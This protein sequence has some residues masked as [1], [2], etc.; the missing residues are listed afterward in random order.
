MPDWTAPFHVPR[1]TTEEFQR[2]KAEYV[3][4]YGYRYTIPGFDDIFHIP[5]EAPITDAEDALWKARRKDEISPERREEIEYIKAKRKAKYLDMLGSPL[6]EVLVSRAALLT[7]IDDAQDAMSTLAIAGMVASRALPPAARAVMMTGTGWIMI[8]GQCLNLA[9]FGLA[10]EQMALSRKRLQDQMTKDNP[11][12]KKARLKNAKKLLKGGFGFGAALEVAQTTDQVFGWG[13]SLGAVMSLPLSIITGAAKLVTGQKLTVYYP[14]PHIPRW[15]RI[16]KKMHPAMLAFNGVFHQTDDIEM[17]GYMMAANAAAQMELTDLSEWNPLD[18]VLRPDMATFPPPTPTKGYLLEILEETDPNWRDTVLWP[19]T[20]TYRPTTEHLVNATYARATENFRSY[21][22]RQK[23][24]ELGFIGAQNVSL[25][26]MNVLEALE[27]R[28]SVEYDY[29]AWCKTIHA[30]L[31]QGY[32]PPTDLS[33][34]QKA[35]F[36]GWLEAHEKLGSCPTTREAFD[37]AQ[38]SCGWKFVRE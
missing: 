3:A 29:T 17:T 6:P 15:R 7:S 8:A 20:G 27:G 12:S 1:M 30:L 36:A 35:C 34:E 16:A 25:S 5:I 24:S 14:V 37:Y 26:G 19:Q 4:K 33:D 28:D 22:E 10:P 32:V 31:D 9:T 23:Y 13:I 2:K 18:S 11:F 21:A 38:Y